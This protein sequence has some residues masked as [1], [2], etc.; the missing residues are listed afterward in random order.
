MK[1]PALICNLERRCAARHEGQA[2]TE[3][4]M[5]ML[6]LFVAIFAIFEGGRLIQTQQMLTDAARYGARLSVAPLTQTS[7]L[8]TPAQIETQVKNFLQTAHLIPARSNVAVNQNVA[9][10]T[11][12]FTRVTVTYDYR[13][14]TLSMFGPL[15]MTL[16]GRSLMRNETSP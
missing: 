15:N 5:T 3:A 14:M 16:T 12:V 13:I 6:L 9:V 2:L 7:T 8:L 11:G 1:N 10:G 4:A